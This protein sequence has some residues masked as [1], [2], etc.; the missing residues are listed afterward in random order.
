MIRRIGNMLQMVGQGATQEAR[1]NAT[2]NT[3]PSLSANAAFLDRGNVVRSN[4]DGTYEIDIETQE[5][6]RQ[7]C[8]ALTDES[9]LDNTS[10]WVSKTTSGTWVIHGSVK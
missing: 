7:T 8:A 1:G 3:Q 4:P 9:L 10:V 5:G 2:A 6:Q